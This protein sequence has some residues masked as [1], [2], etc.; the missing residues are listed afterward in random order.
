[1]VLILS[2]SALV[3]SATIFT[4]AFLLT[5]R[6]SQKLNKVINIVI[7]ITV[8]NFII[9]PLL[10]SFYAI[11]TTSILIFVISPLIVIG[12]F[13]IMRIGYKPARLFFIS[14][15]ILV[16]GGVTFTLATNGIIP[17]NSITLNAAI[18]SALI[19]VILLS[20]ALAVRFNELRREKEDAQMRELNIQAEL[21]K[22][23]ARFVPP[24][25][26]QFLGKKSIIDLNLGDAVQ[27]DMTIFFLDIRGFTTLSEKMTPQENFEFLN[28]LLGRIAPVIRRFHGFIDKFIGDAV[29]ALFEGKPENAIN[30]AILINRLLNAFNKKRITSGAAKLKIGIGIH[31]GSLMF[32]TIGEKK[33]MEGTVISDAVNLSA[34]LEGLTKNYGA[35]ILI[36]DMTLFQIEN[37][38]EYN[39]RLVDRVKVKGRSDN[40]AVYEILDGEEAQQ[41]I[42]TKADFER[43]LDR[44]LNKDFKAA[45]KLFRKVLKK[46][47][48]D[49]AATLYLNRSTYYTKH[50][51]PLEWDGVENMENK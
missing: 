31:T 10:G 49:Q 37:P 17:A 44:Y 38:D 39:F 27:K 45:S 34:R 48:S 13:I 29:L 40:V 51:V 36:S 7:G 16:I 32:G 35:S 30:A 8:I 25:I 11:I 22:S 2:G 4:K 26:F 47:N 5:A 1:M 33:R 23:Y 20:F 50:G 41:K 14:W 42:L 46:A 6:H 21:T 3:L 24:Q 18:V 9:T 12:S 15:T 19:E 28:G 43:G